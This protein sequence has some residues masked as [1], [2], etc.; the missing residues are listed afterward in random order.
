[1]K[2]FNNLLIVSVAAALGLTACKKDYLDRKPTN[3]AAMDDVFNTM[4]GARAAINGIHRTMYEFGGDQH[5]SFGQPSLCLTYD[6]MGEDLI[7]NGQGHF[8]PMYNWSAQRAG[9]ANGA[10]L[11]SF[12]YR[13]INNAN[14]IITNI[15]NVPGEQAER[16][17]IKAQALFYRA[18][19]YYNLANCFSF[20]Y[21][22]DVQ[23]VIPGTSSLPG[24]TGAVPGSPCV[25]LY[26]APTQTGNP[27]ATVDQ[28][29]TQINS[30]LDQ[31][32]A[33]FDGAGISRSDKSQVDISV[34]RG[35]AARVAL[36][37]QQWP[38]AAAM[39]H[40]ARTSYAYMSVSQLLGGFNDINNNE[41]MW[42][43][44]INAEQATSYA[45]FVSF[46]DS[47]A[48]GYAY[49]H[50]Q[51]VILND[52]LNTKMDTADARRYWWV[53]RKQLVDSAA[54]YANY[55]QN[56]QRKFKVKVAGTWLADYPYMRAGEMALIE[57]EA[58]AQQNNRTQAGQVLE[59]FVKTR[60][61][62]FTANTS[63][64]DTLIK[65]IWL[66][67]RIELWGEGFR[68][69]DIKR[70][71]GR[72]TAVNPGDNT[73]LHRYGN[74]NSTVGNGAKDIAATDVRFLWRIPGGELLQNNIL[75]NP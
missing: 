25:P 10:Y 13:I 63:N 32:I 62:N 39:A 1:M 55:K 31:A 65:Q 20:S 42:G 18:Y 58:L 56:E 22:M 3:Q 17:E 45:S 16:D 38:R 35:L 34:A 19:A 40:D 57:A 46:M 23:V 47:D 59:E 33:L 24:Y 49:I 26:T 51:M 72:F 21:K 7:P 15:D 70:Q 73:G 8:N 48:Q 52:I 60:N 53:A 4:S 50:C 66:Q 37:Q 69:F 29:Y 41:W 74:W 14:L 11:W 36:V 27:R 28:I 43:S 2:L 6:L 71:A 30:D 68:Y 64:S 61:V 75:Q 12:Y 67:R 5:Y 44:A 54:K 9:T